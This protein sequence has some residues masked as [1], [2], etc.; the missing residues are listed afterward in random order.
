ATAAQPD[1]SGHFGD[2]DCGLGHKLVGHAALPKE[3]WGGTDQRL[4]TCSRPVAVNCRRPWSS[5]R[6]NP[7]RKRNGSTTCETVPAG[8][9]N[10]E[11]MTLSRLAPSASTR[12]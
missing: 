5:L 11:A 1:H 12:R 9:P 4:E 10:M 2:R 3:S 6:I 8:R 7:L